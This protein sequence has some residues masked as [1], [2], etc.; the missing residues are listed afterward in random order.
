MEELVKVCEYELDKAIVNK[1]IEED[2]KISNEDVKIEIHEI[3][4]DNKIEYIGNYYIVENGL[5][6]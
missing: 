2:R 4:E 3:L 6:K 1:C 5:L